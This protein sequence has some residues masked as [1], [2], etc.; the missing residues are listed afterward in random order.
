[1]LRL[2]FCSLRSTQ[3]DPNLGS[4][5]G[6]VLLR[7]PL[8]PE[9]SIINFIK[10]KKKAATLIFLLKLHPHCI[11]ALTGTA[12]KPLPKEIAFQPRCSTTPCK[13]AN[14]T[15]HPK[16]ATQLIYSLCTSIMACTAFS[17]PTAALRARE[18]ITPHFCSP[19]SGHLEPIFTHKILNVG[20][21][22][23][24]VLFPQIGSI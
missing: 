1:L 7:K 8:A 9:G 15:H 14:L 17:R 23:P 10:G 4:N 21:A 6:K 11:N 13:C 12:Y 18:I 16:G 5:S 22:T 19:S 24:A 3:S 20:F 2:R